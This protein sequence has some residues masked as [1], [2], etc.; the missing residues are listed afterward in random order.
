MCVYVCGCVAILWALRKLVHEILL[1]TT[2][3]PHVI[4]MFCFVSGWRAF[5]SVSLCEYMF[6]LSDSLKEAIRS[7]VQ[8][9]KVLNVN[10][11]LGKQQQAAHAQHTLAPR[12]A[13]AG[14][15]GIG[16]AP[17]A[18]KALHGKALVTSCDNLGGASRRRVPHSCPTTAH[19]QEAT[20][21]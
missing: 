16:L 14:N 18:C 20:I 21:E 10:V 19:T 2:N 11:T 1:H 5:S 8:A 15:R 6:C 7:S 3:S 12:T 13:R 17:A 9:L 4:L